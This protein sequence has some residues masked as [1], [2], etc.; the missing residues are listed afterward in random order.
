[1]YVFTDAPAKAKG[2]FTRDNA[3]GY[4]LDYMMSI[5]F[6]FS[7]RGCS[8]P[9]KSDDY[10]ALIEDTRGIGLFFQNPSA[11]VNAEGVI[12]SDLDG[13]CTVY[14]GCIGC[15]SR[16]RRD[17]MDLIRRTTR[18]I[19]FPVDRTIYRLIVSTSAA[20]NIAKVKLMD[21]SGNPAPAA[22]PMVNGKLW[23]IEKPAKGTWTLVSD[24]SITKRSYQVN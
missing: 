23:L 22:L 1:M 20:T 11:F 4:A 3:I 9:S 21:P 13:S 16:R 15:S 12:K 6:F 5:N 2:E 24:S 14:G 8:D 19:V 17:L 10:K 18:N 7:T